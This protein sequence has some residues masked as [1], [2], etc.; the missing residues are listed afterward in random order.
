MSTTDHHLDGNAFAAILGEILTCEPTTAE[1][2]CQSCRAR[3]RMG[4]HLAY[5]GA[6]LVL[7][8]PSCGDVAV[9]VVQLPRAQVVEFRGT[10]VF[11]TAMAR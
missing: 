6:G 8:C 7:R 2:I 3:H 4:E 11:E 1:R 9:R 5:G 10:W